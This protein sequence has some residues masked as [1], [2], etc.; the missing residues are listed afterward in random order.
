MHIQGSMPRLQRRTWQPLKH[1][2]RPCAGPDDRPMETLIQWRDIAGANFQLFRNDAK[3][4]YSLCAIVVPNMDDARAAL[5]RA[6]L[7]LGDV[8]EGDYGKI[9]KLHDPDGNELTL[10]EPLRS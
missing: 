9:A 2:I 1:S 5:K 10:A 7:A 6:S 8:R 4:G 3:A